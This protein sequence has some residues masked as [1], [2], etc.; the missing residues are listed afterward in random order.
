[1]LATVAHYLFETRRVAQVELARKYEIM[2]LD[3]VDVEIFVVIGERC[4]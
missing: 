2:L 1:M 3:K 4:L